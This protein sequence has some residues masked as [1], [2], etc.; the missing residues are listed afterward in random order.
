MAKLSFLKSKW[1]WAGVIVVVVA[2]GWYWRSRTANQGPF[3]ETQ[4]LALGDV[5]QTVEVTGQ[6]KPQDRINLSFKNSGTL[7]AV[8]VKIGDKVKAGDVLA[9]LQARD[10]KYAV[11]LAAA[12]L[13]TAQANLNAKLAGE[14]PESI[15]IAQAA[16]D[17]VQAAVDQAKSNLEITRLSVE[18]EYRVAQIAVDTAKQNLDNSGAS[19]DQTVTNSYESLRA[20]LQTAI[21]AVQSGLGDGDAIIG[22]D[23]SAANDA[24]EGVLGLSDRPSLQSAQ[25]QYPVAKAA[26]QLANASVLALSSLSSHDAIKLAANQMKDALE[27]TRI[28]LDYVHRTLDGTVTNASLTVTDLTAKKATIS[29]D[30]TAVATQLTNVTTGLQAITNSTLS[31]NTAFAQLQNAY[32]TALQ[33]LQIADHDRQTKVKAAETAVAVQTAALASAKATLALKLAPPRNVDIASLRA[34]VTNAAT[35]YNQAKDRLTDVQIVAPVDGIVSDI[36]PAIGEQAVAN[37]TAVSMIA[38]A[39]FTIEALIP[40]ADIA[41][42]VVGDPVTLTL[43]AF[44]DDVKF[45][46]KVTAENPDQ[47]KVQDAIYYKTYVSIDPG[48]KDVKPGMTANLTVQTGKKDGVL[49]VASRAIRDVNGEK[50]VRVLKN[51][52]AQDTTVTLGLKGDEGRTEILSGLSVGQQIVIGELTAAEYAAQK[53]TP[54]P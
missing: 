26:Y 5:V 32:D 28:Y 22:V 17:Q 21:S 19:S 24:Y 11:D 54:T 29:A 41:K 36:V 3:Y 23:N 10:V 12:S 6:I 20:T 2:G 9:Q 47:T 35:A 52:V 25:S 27:K 33:N 51:G 42:V 15:Q 38:T 48:D 1:L 8:N 50:V 31:Y 18:D 45:N 49:Y 53:A 37:V 34:Q 7:A 13:A 14:T 16:V 40:E 44:G 30:Q 39:D 43:D 46:G 4:T